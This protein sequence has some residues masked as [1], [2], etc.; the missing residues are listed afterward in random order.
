MKNRILILA[1]HSFIG[2]GTKIG[3]QHLA[4]GLANRG[5]YVD[6]VSVGSSWFDLISKQRRKRLSRVW[7]GSASSATGIPLKE[8]LTEYSARLPFPIHR[9]FIKYRWQLSWV[10]NCLPRS[11]R[12]QRYDVVIYESSPSIVWLEQISAEHR[13]FRLNDYPAGFSTSLP[14]VVVN[15]FTRALEKGVE[16]VWAVSKPL[17]DWVRSQTSQGVTV[18]LLPNGVAASQVVGTHLSPRCRVDSCRAVFVG[19]LDSP[20]LDRELLEAVA[21]HL[22]SWHFDLFGPGRWK[23]ASKP[24][25]LC[26]KGPVHA[27]EVAELLG[28]YDVGLIPY[29]DVDDRMRF[30]ERPLKF[31]EY[32]GAGLGVAST[33]VGAMKAGMGDLACYGNDAQ[34]FANAILAARE[35]AAQR[36]A[37]FSE[38]F[39]KAH[40]WASVVDQAARRLDALL[41]E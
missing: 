3:I 7:F 32:I 31:Y 38:Q 30:V 34:G 5:W 12:E 29:R 40:S 15:E 14:K 13:V 19:D 6:Y 9:L 2:V 22:P 36:P 28:H 37:G 24:K 21:K 1:T 20:W 11:L 41:A 35:A 18:E 33:D 25:N 4:E 17:A 23:S 26:I 39:L 10:K 27:N 8:G 16:E